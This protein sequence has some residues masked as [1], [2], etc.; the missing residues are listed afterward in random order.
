MAAVERFANDA[1]V[2]EQAFATDDWAGLPAG[3][4]AVGNAGG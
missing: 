4:D 3:R 2:F 1:L